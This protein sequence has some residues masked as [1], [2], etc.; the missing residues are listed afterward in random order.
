MK[1]MK[2]SKKKVAIICAIIGATA[3]M[4]CAIATVA[5]ALITREKPESIDTVEKIQENTCV[6][7][8]EYVLDILQTTINAVMIGKEKEGS[9]TIDNHG[10]GIVIYG[11]DNDPTIIKEIYVNKATE[12]TDDRERPYT[13]RETYTSERS[14][15]PG[16]EYNLVCI[17]TRMSGWAFVTYYTYDV[18]YY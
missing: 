13:V 12:Q 10:D 1:K 14:G 16:K 18:T 17:D 3:T 7:S 4:S 5:A 6:F 2:Q 9:I 15:E 11:D 8:E